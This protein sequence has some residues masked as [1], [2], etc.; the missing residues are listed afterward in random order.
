MV[1]D[2]ETQDVLELTA[3]DDQQPVEAL[4]A[5]AGSFRAAIVLVVCALAAV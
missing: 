2:V 4:A 5:G 1:P 3:A